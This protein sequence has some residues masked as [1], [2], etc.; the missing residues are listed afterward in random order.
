MALMIIE[1]WHGFSGL[2]FTVPFY[3]LYHIMLYRVNFA[4]AGFEPTTL[5]V[6]DTD[7][8]GSYK[9]YYHTITNMMAPYKKGKIISLQHSYYSNLH[10]HWSQYNVRSKTVQICL[11]LRSGI[12]NTIMYF[13]CFSHRSHLSRRQWRRRNNNITRTWLK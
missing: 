5:V 2:W 9:S 7:C 13:I 8:K 3:K 4:W 11:S 6:I 10:L 1:K 12:Y